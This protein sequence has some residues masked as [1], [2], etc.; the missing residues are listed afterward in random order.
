MRIGYFLEDIETI[1]KNREQAGPVRRPPVFTEEQKFQKD[2]EHH[3]F[4]VHEEGPQEAAPGPVKR[5]VKKAV[6]AETI[7]YRPRWEEDEDG[8]N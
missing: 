2:L 1:R 5:V 3:D 7:E 6:K 4:S 8:E